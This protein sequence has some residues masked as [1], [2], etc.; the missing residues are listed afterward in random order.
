MPSAEFR[1]PRI[2]DSTRNAIGLGFSYRPNT[3]LSLD[4]GYMYISFDD[5]S[6]DNTVNLIPSP[7]GLITDTL[8]VDYTGSGNLVGLQ[9]NYRF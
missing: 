8:R 1:T 7:A 5:A 6:T 9:A 2:P 3:Q 4:F